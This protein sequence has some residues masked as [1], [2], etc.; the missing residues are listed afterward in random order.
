MGKVKEKRLAV[1]SLL[2]LIL[3]AIGIEDVKN[4]EAITDF[5]FD[6]VNKTADPKHWTNVDV[7]TSFKRW[8]E[9]QAM[10]EVGLDG[11]YG[12]KLNTVGELRDAMSELSDDDQICIETIDLETGDVQDL[13]PMYLDV[14][15]GIKLTTGQI[16]NEVR[17]CQM[18]NK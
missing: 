18:K 2:I 7:Q 14:I 6:D 11:M 12:V 4:I 1:Q 13:Y 16:I 10:S 9:A 15:D 5:V 17:F 3:H 8:M